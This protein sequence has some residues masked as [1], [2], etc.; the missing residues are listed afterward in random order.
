MT[1]QQEDDFKS[2]YAK[3]RRKEGGAR[4]YYNRLMKAPLLRRCPYCYDR[5]V[6]EID[7]YLPRSSFARLAVVPLNLVPLCHGCNKQKLNYAPSPSRPPLLHPYFDFAE[8]E[9]WIGSSLDE[10][11]FVT[12]FY[13]NVPAPWDED[14]RKRVENHFEV[15]KLGQ[16]WSGS[17]AVYFS[18]VWARLLRIYRASGVFAVQ[19]YLLEE[20]EL[21]VEGHAEPWKFALLMAW[22]ES[23]W[24]CECRWRGLIMVELELLLDDDY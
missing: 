19:D 5:Q 8:S 17:A 4:R 7:H 21:V 24:F 1:A 15:M 18:T 9:Q 12:T 20:A 2:G 3:L 10:D 16:F 13:V 6:S 22:A 11:N 14:T 23:E